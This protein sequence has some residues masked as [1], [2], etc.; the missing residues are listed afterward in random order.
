MLLSEV[1]KNI[2]GEMLSDAEFDS[3]AFITDRTQK[4][5][6]TFFESEKLLNELNNTQI[7][8]VITSEKFVKL[9][10]AHI[11]GIFVCEEPK[12]TLLKIHNSLVK[13]L[14]Y[15]GPKIPTRV[16]DECK[17]SPLSYIDPFNVCIGKNVTIEPF[18]TIKGRVTIGDNVTIHSGGII[19]CKGFSFSKNRYKENEPVIDTAQIVIEDNVELFEQVAISTGIFPWEKTVIGENTKIDTQCFIAHGTQIGHNCLIVAGSR[20]CGNCIIGHNVWIGAGAIISNRITVGDNARVS[21]GA[22][23]TK[24][25]PTG[26]I[27]SGNFAINHQKFL[28]NLKMSIK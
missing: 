27:V 21:L 1:V 2:L 15:V 16:G 13:N 7:S 11:K 23:V 9:I 25:V 28:E 20:C 26:M 19:G 12:N 3:L 6:L 14:E 22:V 18:V 17:I 8:C 10:P 4:N 24:D 5:F